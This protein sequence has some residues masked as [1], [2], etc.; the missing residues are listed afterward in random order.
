MLSE[1]IDSVLLTAVTMETLRI[2]LFTS[3]NR[4]SVN[5]IAQHFLPLRNESF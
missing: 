1:R 3:I 4:S 5:P 2:A